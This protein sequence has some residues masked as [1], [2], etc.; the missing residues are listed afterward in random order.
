MTFHEFLRGSAKL[1][2]DTA[3]TTKP[4]PSLRVLGQENQNYALRLTIL[5]PSR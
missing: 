3:K 4:F 2:H 1:S 5:S